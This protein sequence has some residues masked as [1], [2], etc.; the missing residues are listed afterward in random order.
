MT[1]SNPYS[2]LKIVWHPE[3]LD[4]LRRGIVTAPI[5]VLVQP[6]NRCDHRC[7]YCSYMDHALGLRTAVN[8][9]D[10]ISW[11]IFKKV[12]ADIAVMKVKSVILSGGG[13]PLL[14]PKIKEKIGR[15]SCRERV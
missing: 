13:E 6:T 3:K 15:A 7:F 9:R 5:N 1:T 8:A 11:E 14:Y 4:A 2:N 10:E 12:L